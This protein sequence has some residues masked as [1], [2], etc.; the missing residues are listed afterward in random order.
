MYHI[1]SLYV[2][3]F[4]L[5]NLITKLTIYSI[6]NKKIVLIWVN[7][8]NP[9]LIRCW[10]GNMD[11]QY[12]LDPFAAIVYMLS[13]LTKSEREMGDLLRNAQRE[14]REGNLNA[15]SELKKLGSVY[16]QHRE[17]SVMNAIYLICSMPLKRS[18][19][20]VVFV[21]TDADGQ[22]ISLPSSRR[23]L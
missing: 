23:L 16:L 22:K 19:R 1:L 21:Q 5:H 17:I 18:S 12:I 11:I 3:W 8:Y 9:D 20:N 6:K 14:A 2:I 15:L 7:N 13:Y 4:E 10:N